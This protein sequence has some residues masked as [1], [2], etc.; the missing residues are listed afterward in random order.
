MSKHTPGPWDVEVHDDH[1]TV[2][3][4]SFT[5]CSDVSNDDASLIAA[6]PDMLAALKDF[7]AYLGEGITPSEEVLLCKARAAIAKA[8]DV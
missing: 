3:S 2:E 4:K 1:T 6:C 7:V 5:I 8:E